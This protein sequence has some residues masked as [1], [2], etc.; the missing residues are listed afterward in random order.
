MSSCCIG[1]DVVIERERSRAW[2]FLIA[3][4]DNS[5]EGLPCLER[6][7]LINST[8]MNLRHAAALARAGKSAAG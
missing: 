4:N 7:A 1:C 2:R 5:L 8:S 3:G 6:A